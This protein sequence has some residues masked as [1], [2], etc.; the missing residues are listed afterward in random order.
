[1]VLLVLPM[2]ERLRN[3]PYVHI[4]SFKVSLAS[5]AEEPWAP[6]KNS[7]KPPD[8]HND[9]QAPRNRLRADP[10]T[11]PNLYWESLKL[12]LL[13]IFCPP[14]NFP[15]GGGGESWCRGFR[16]ILRYIYF[17]ILVNSRNVYYI[18]STVC[19]ENKNTVKKCLSL[20][21]HDFTWKIFFFSMTHNTIFAVNM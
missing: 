7:S 19:S 9:L 20:K 16:T 11:S 21:N 18:H 17:S 15:P 6:Q 10:T 5:F 3:W 4:I 14:L 12:S 8:L 1:M 2:V 13:E